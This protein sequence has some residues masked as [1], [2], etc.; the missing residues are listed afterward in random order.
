MVIN[1]EGMVGRANAGGPIREWQLDAVGLVE[2]RPALERG[3][4]RVQDEAV[5]IKN[6]QVHKPGIVPAHDLKNKMG[7][8]ENLALFKVN[9]LKILRNQPLEVSEVEHDQ[10]LKFPRQL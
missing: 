8:K 6:K 5:K 2:F 9:S 3:R 4:F 1:I 7:L 10:R